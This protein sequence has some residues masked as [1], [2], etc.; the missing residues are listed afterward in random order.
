MIYNIQQL[1]AWKNP[2]RSD[3]I[4]GDGVLPTQ[5]KLMIFGDPKAWKSGLSLYTAYQIAQGKL[6][7]GYKTTKT[8]VFRLQVELPMHVDQKRIR[9]F[10]NSANLYP[11][12]ILFKTESRLKLDTGIGVSSLDRDL[13][14]IATEYPNQNV[15]LILDPMYKLLRGHI[16]DSRDVQALLDNLDELKDKHKFSLIL[17]HHS[18]LPHYDIFGKTIEGGAEDAMGSS[19]FPDW[20][21]TM[22]KV[23]LLDPPPGPAVTV[24]MTFVL[25][26]HA[27]YPLPEFEVRWSRRTLAPTITKR[28]IPEVLSEDDVTIRELI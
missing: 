16:S 8:L 20:V 17:V 14:W 2:D 28:A 5:S 11:P 12:N 24:R 21:D 22:L 23:K 25:Y 3:D 15:L 26:R 6:W 19:Y 27:E 18:R 4:I 9:K 13:K 7:F 1:L 10:A